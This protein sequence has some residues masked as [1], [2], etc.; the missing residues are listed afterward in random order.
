[1]SSGRKKKQ[2]WVSSLQCACLSSQCW[3]GGCHGDRSRPLVIDVEG[4]HCTPPTT[5]SNGL[6][7]NG[8]GRP[9]S[10]VRQEVASST[11]G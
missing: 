10:G 7:V 4:L 3:K 9:K 2:V 5:T 1:V 11:T 6:T 8:G